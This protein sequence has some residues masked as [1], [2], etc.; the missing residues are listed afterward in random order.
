MLKVVIETLEQGVKYV[1]NNEGGKA[2]MTFCSG[3]VLK[4][5]FLAKM[6]RLKVSNIDIIITCKSCSKL[7]RHQIGVWCL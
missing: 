5:G 4:H 7:T 6:Y 2:I 3:V 1:I